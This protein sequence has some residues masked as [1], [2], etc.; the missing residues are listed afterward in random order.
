M[1]DVTNY[2]RSYE[3]A[4]PPSFCSRVVELF[5]SD[6]SR[7]RRNGGNIRSGLVESSWVEMDLSDCREFNFRNIIVNCLRHY[8]SVYEKDCGIV[9]PLPDAVNLAPLIVKR[10]DPGGT[11]RFQP[12]YDSVGEV[13]NRYMVFL[14]YLNDVEQGGETDFVDL[15]LSS[16]PTT[17][18]L[19]IFPPYW[20]YRHAGQPPVSG[21][22]YILSTYPLW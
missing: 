14:W 20:M 5:E 2:I 9:P 13:A 1:T 11:D 18:K 15:N 4:L 8:K 7:Q 6:S 19:L 21:S 12:H 10:Y 17:G 22:K 16:S 3:A